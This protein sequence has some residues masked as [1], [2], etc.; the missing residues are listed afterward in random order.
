MN[1][2]VGDH[3]TNGPWRFLIPEASAEPSA[4]ASEQLVD[5]I[6]ATLAGNRGAP[7]RRSRHA[8]TWRIAAKSGRIIFVKQIDSARGLVARIKSRSRITRAGHVLRISD[9]LRRDGFGV[10]RPILIG[11]NLDTGHQLIVTPEVAGKMVTRW[12]NPKYAVAMPERRTILNQLGE[13]IARLHRSGYIHGDLTPYNIFAAN[14]DRARITFIDH[15]RTHK[16]SR[17]GF[18]LARERLRNLVQLGH[19]EIPGVSRSDK[20]R[21]FN[22]YSKAYGWTK[23]ARRRSLKRLVK[24]INRRVKKD[25][26]ASSIEAPPIVIE[27]R[28]AQG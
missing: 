26:A 7:F 5:L 24:M 3:L 6:L 12:M 2:A 28:R 20:L 22:S 8:T 18:N 14:E 1:D 15:E 4:A 21:V 23:S 11:E 9:E 17:L 25:R 27:G 10:P 13:E 19:F 16:T